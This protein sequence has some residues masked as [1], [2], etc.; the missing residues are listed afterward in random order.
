MD[1]VEYGLSRLSVKT[2][3]YV[4]ER[5]VKDVRCN[6]CGM[7]VL[8]SDLREHGY[9]YQC[10]FCDEDLFEFETYAGNDRTALEAIEIMLRVE[11]IE[12][13]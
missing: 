1:S 6:R 13:K 5:L 2:V 4:E 7:P 9:E 10:V 11:E 3:R 8:T 12:C